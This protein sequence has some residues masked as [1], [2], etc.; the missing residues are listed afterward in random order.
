MKKVFKI[1]GI[2]FFSLMFIGVIANF[3]DKSKK[4]SDVLPEKEKVDQV[5]APVEHKVGDSLALM[6]EYFAV[7]IENVK[8]TKNINT[9]NEFSNLA[10]QPG[11]KFVVLDMVFKNMDT[12]SRM[13]FD[14]DI[15]INYHGKELKYDKTET[16]MAE[17][18][19]LM[20][21]QINP[22]TQK[23]TKLVYA[24]PEEVKGAA[25]Y[26]PSR[27]DDNERIYLGNL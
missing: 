23:N 8:V 16:V 26:H 14:G 25:Y 17:G 12:E 15:L 9:G 22:L 19:G 1:I 20:L 13:L 10:A 7:W 27:S 24:I 18:Y 11:N 5:V 4:T 6:T 3:F 21:D 2:V